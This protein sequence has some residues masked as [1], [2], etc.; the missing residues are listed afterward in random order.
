MRILF[1]EA[2]LGSEV[3]DPSRK[4]GIYRVVEQTALQLRRA[5]AEPANQLEVTFHSTEHLWASRLYYQKYLQ[6]RGTRFSARAW[7]LAVARYWHEIWRFCARTAADR[8]PVMR[9]VRWTMTRGQR[10]IGAASSRLSRATLE[11]TDIY[12]SPFRQIPAS[13]YHHRRL[14]RFTTV[15]D[16][17]PIT[18]PGWFEQSSVDILRGVLGSFQPADFVTCI[19]QAT[20]MQLLELAPQLQPD[21]VFVTH[22]A[23]GDW[24][25]RE[26]NPARIAE[27]GTM[28]GLESG[29]P[30]FLSLCTLEPRKNLEAIIRAFGRLRKE[31]QIGDE[32]RL[33]LVGRAGWKTEKIL[34]A[35]EEAKHCREAIVVT[36]F[37]PD[38]YL[39]ALYSGALAFLYVSRLEGFGLPPLE[40]MQCGVPVIT[41]NVSSLPEVVGDAALT[42]GPDDIDGLCASMLR[43]S[44]DE[45]LRNELGARSRARARM[46][47]WDRFGEETMAAYRGAM[48]VT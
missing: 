47:S 41:S 13:V 18:H 25:H 34:A 16:L 46:F 24:C 8:N 1:N 43:L 15:Y 42:V 38:E 5:A 3:Y 7:Q 44:Q 6:G 9:G 12:H 45:A 17:I 4:D 48:A 20:R 22:L 29:T 31:R 32:T 33:V 2:P 40:A 23:A 11:A 27:V 28:F 10:A 14:R 36:G 35:L 19:S 30:Y 21:R 39:P 37:V 26:E